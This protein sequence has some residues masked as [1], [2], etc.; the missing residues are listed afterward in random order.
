MRL[1]RRTSLPLA[2]ANGVGYAFLYEGGMRHHTPGAFGAIT[3]KYLS[4]ICKIIND[5]LLPNFP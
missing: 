3:P 2:P 1:F 4:R 5:S